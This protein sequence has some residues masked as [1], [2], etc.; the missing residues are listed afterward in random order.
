VLS[1]LGVEKPA[2]EASVV[3]ILSALTPPDPE[4]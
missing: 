1:E 2:V 4:G 3:N